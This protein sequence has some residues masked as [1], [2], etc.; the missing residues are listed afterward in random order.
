MSHRSRR[1]TGYLVIGTLLAALVGLASPAAAAVP[2]APRAFTA[3]IEPNTAYVGQSSCDPVLRWGTARLGQLLARTYPGT[4]W[5]AVYACGT[6]GTQ[7][8]HY[9]GRAIDWM[10]SSRNRAQHAEG[11]AF[12]RWLL[13]TD[14]FGNTT[15][16]ARRLGVMYVIFNGWM[17]GAWNNRWVEYDG[18]QHGVR[19][20]AAWDN[21]CHRTHMHVSLS[22]NGAR[23]HTTF[24]T[25]GVWRTDYGPCRARGQKFAPKWSRRNF[26]PCPRT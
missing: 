12:Y 6:D 13:A 9:E 5:A 14:R 26:V 4:R 20:T 1:S 16:M 2:R 17:W 3:A 22:W 15:A 23:G 10:V 24:W 7:S 21:F 19:R 8:E 25:G 18:C 11:Q